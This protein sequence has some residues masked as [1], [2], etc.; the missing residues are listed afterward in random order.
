MDILEGKKVDLIISDINMPEMDGVQ[1]YLKLKE[2]E[3]LKSVPVV[4]LTSRGEIEDI[5]YASLLGMD[6]YLAKPFDPEELRSMLEEIL[7]P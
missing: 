2:R 5:R 6:R 4:M 3:D 7:G 1:L